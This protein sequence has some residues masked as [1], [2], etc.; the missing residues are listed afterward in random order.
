M[1]YKIVLTVIICH[2]CEK[3]MIA[4][5]AL[6]LKDTFAPRFASIQAILDPVEFLEN[7]EVILAKFSSSCCYM[8][9]FS[10]FF[11][12]FIFCDVG[13]M[14]SSHFGLFPFRPQVTSAFCN[15]GPRRFGPPKRPFG[16]PI[17][18][19]NE[20]FRPIVLF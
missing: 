12:V 14:V 15:F 4:H 7:Y 18:L 19:V 9:S 5:A 17:G 6:V 2:F 1:F 11:V 13:Q 16:L 8:L 10:I 20:T 3:S